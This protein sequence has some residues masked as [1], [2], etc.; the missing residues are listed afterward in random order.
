MSLCF[1][2]RLAHELFMKSGKAIFP[3][4]PGIN[5]LKPGE[6]GTLIDL[7]QSHVKFSEEKGGKKKKAILIL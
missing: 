3:E 6:V 2:W 7:S 1:H 5:M 4:N